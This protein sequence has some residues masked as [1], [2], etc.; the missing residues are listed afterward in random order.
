MV[1]DA[2]KTPSV[3]SP[4]TS[5]AKRFLRNF[6]S[7]SAGTLTSRVTGFIREIVIA[8]AVGNGP[9]MDAFVA[10]FKIPTLFRRVLGED[11][12]ERAFMPPFRS[13]ISTGKTK[14]AWRLFSAL[15]TIMALALC[16]V[17]AA[18]YMLAPSIVAIIAPG[19]AP[20]IFDLTV[21][22]TYV[23]LP[24]MVAIGL[25]AFAGG[26]LNFFEKNVPYAF[27]PVMLSVGVVLGLVALRPVLTAYGYGWAALPA[28]FVLGAVL[29]L[30][31]QLPWV[32]GSGVRGRYEMRIEPTLKTPLGSAGS[33]G[34]ESLWITGQ[35][36]LSK[37]VEVL[38]T[39]LAS[40]LASG[41]IGALYFAQRLVQLPNAIIG[42]AIA[43]AVAPALTV[44]HATE[45]HDEFKQEFLR[46]WR[47]T[48]LLVSPMM[49]MCVMLSAPVVRLVYERGA[50]S[51]E[52][53]QLTGL[54]FWGYSVGLLG[55]GVYGLLVRAFSVIGRN[56][57]PAIATV[58]SVVFNVI[59]DLILVET[60][61]RH[62]GIA[63][64]ASVAVTLNAAFLF[65]RL[66]RYLAIQGH[67]FG[68]GEILGPVFKVAV[69]SVVMAVALWWASGV[70][71]TSSETRILTALADLIV[72]AVVGTAAYVACSLALPVREVV[73]LR[74]A[75]G[76]KLSRS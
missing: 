66:N 76:S 34:R 26:L 71:S 16:A 67:G 69:N 10:A 40:F 52:G 74:H 53:V 45:N 17:T 51:A 54:A 11:V 4:E 57:L 41:S 29:Q 35:S 7:L 1:E 27:A 47:Y 31:V 21:R 15:L 33:V 70:W 65:W 6:A 18:L 62:G 24:F 32:L 9:H 19:L 3:S 37:S 5:A 39:Y 36:F 28:G 42:L 61:L 59:L 20:P 63:L 60:R 22:M 2:E 72:P 75:I 8:G 12:V 49:V 48:L 64:A 68:L 44:S 13:L 43:R 73:Q 14:E 46:G 23:V 30:L 50:F 58:I 55:M 38:D 56:R 25:A